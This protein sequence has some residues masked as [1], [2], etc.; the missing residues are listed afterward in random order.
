MKFSTQKKRPLKQNL[1]E[2]L[3]FLHQ[4]LLMIE[5]DEVDYTKNC[6]WGTVRSKVTLSEIKNEKES[7]NTLIIT[8]DT[9]ES[10]LLSWHGSK[11]SGMLFCIRNAFAH[12]YVS[13]DSVNQRLH[14][15]LLNQNHKPALIGDISLNALNEIVNLIRESHKSNKK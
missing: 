15:E 4:V 10:L 13:F 3:P 6:N 14:F 8:K 2:A 7:K 9:N 12:N 11:A 1:G 5:N